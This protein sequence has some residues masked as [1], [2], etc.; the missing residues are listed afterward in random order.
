MEKNLK[1]FI[2]NVSPKNTR[3]IVEDHV[4]RVELTES[5]EVTINIDRGY[6]FNSLNSHE[7]IGNIIKGVKKTFGDE[8]KVIMKLEAHL[9]R[10]ERFEHHDRE[11]NVPYIIHYN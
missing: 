7:H 2:S 9:K 10:G 4:C 5:D 3:E 1:E 6:A 11:E 8:K